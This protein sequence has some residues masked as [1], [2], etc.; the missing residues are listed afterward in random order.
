VTP[1]ILARGIDT[2]ELGFYC[3]LDEGLLARLDEE[4][5]KL[6]GT[7]ADSIDVE[8]GGLVHKAHRIGHGWKWALLRP[9]LWAVK[10]AQRKHGDPAPSVA[11]AYRSEFL[12][13]R[14]PAAAVWTSQET[15]WPDLGDAPTR[16]IV[17]RAD[18]CMDWSGWI[19]TPEDHARFVRRVRFLSAHWEPDQRERQS[20]F[21]AMHDA[22]LQAMDDNWDRP[23]LASIAATAGLSALR[24]KSRTRYEEAVEEGEAQHSRTSYWRGQVFTGFSWGRGHLGGRWYRKDREIAD[25]SGKRWF[26]DIYWPD[27][28]ERAR[29]VDPEDPTPVM[30]LEFQCRREALRSFKLA[31]GGR[32]VST[33]DDLLAMC[34]GIWKYLAGDWMTLRTP[35]LTRTGKPATRSR[36]PVDDRWAKVRD[37]PF[38]VAACP[39]IRERIRQIDRERSTALAIGGVSRVIVDH[40]QAGVTEAIALDA[41]LDFFGEHA[42]EFLRGKGETWLEHVATSRERIRRPAASALEVVGEPAF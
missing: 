21:A 12:W 13:E 7:G 8:V 25:S 3:E 15:L 32:E 20:V 38:R 11:I 42:R 30:R 37:E 27:E 35:T 23:M 1:T 28:A 39:I 31:P 34:G 9:D 33:L 29:H 36:W 14:G 17:S 26:H 40:P 6:R 22:I 4:W 18:L 41:A 2:L 16:N 24:G 5:E 10:L 19:P